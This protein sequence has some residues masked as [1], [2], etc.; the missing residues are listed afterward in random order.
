M[1]VL[2][3]GSTFGSSLFGGFAMATISPPAPAKT[4]DPVSFLSKQIHSLGADI[5]NFACC[6]ISVS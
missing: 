4:Q 5:A 2:M 6:F 3:Q 1:N